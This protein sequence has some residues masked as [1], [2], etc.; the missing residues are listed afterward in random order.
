M[1]L[2]GPKSNEIFEF[3]EEWNAQLEHADVEHLLEVGNSFDDA[4][5]E[6]GPELGGPSL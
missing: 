4:Q 3:L 5:E 2:S 6:P 1:R